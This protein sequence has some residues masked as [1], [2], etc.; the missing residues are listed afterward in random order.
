MGLYFFIMKVRFLKDHIYYNKGTTS[1]IDDD[2]IAKY[3]I[4]MGVVEEISETE[5]ILKRVK[6]KAK[7]K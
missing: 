1:Y 4:R 7:K 2:N 5:S 3:W 6:D